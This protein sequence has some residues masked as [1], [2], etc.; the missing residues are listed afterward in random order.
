LDKTT[1]L[2]VT[3][4]SGGSAPIILAT[5]VT[6]DDHQTSPAGTQVDPTMGYIEYG[7][8]VS[9]TTEVCVY[10]LVWDPNGN[11]TI[12]SVWTE[13]FHPDYQKWDNLS[14]VADPD[15]SAVQPW[16][17]SEKFQLQM[18][19]ITVG[20]DGDGTAALNAAVAGGYLVSVITPNEDLS[21]VPVA[22]RAALG[23]KDIKEALRYVVQEQ[24]G[25]CMYKVCFDMELHQCAGI[26][27]TQTMA[28]DVNEMWSNVTGPHTPAF[29]GWFDWVASDGILTDF[30]TVNYGQASTSAP[31]WN[32]QGDAS[33]ATPVF[34]TV[35]N[36]G[37]TYV[38]VKVKN[39]D[40]GLGS[41]TGSTDP[42]MH[43]FVVLGSQ[44]NQVQE[45]WPLY[46]DGWS[47]FATCPE[48]LVMCTPTKID[49][50][51]RLLKATALT[52]TIT[53]NGNMVISTDHVDFVSCSE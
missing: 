41:I 26:Y 25:I 4:G 42:P 30:S 17:G 22:V 37:N 36:N 19:P 11:H 13:I 44:N 18:T 5:F 20:A 35:W 33:L 28:V 49:F 7:V 46:G 9:P 21:N 48:V 10:A 1:T 32:A 15:L 50:G 43:Y 23:T 24:T 47:A 45:Y 16:C 2:T 14:L 31:V 51:I 27:A 39:D 53:L 12:T 40:M 38:R 29:A 3:Q 6:P 8:N 34:P 52:S